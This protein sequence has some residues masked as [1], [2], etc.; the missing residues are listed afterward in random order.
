MIKSLTGIIGLFCLS[1]LVFLICAHSNQTPSGNIGVVV[2]NPYIFGHGGVREKYQEPGLSWY[3]STTAV[4][5]TSISPFRMDERIDHLSTA[6]NNFINYNSYLEMEYT[7]EMIIKNVKKFG[8][9]KELWYQN[10]VQQHYR[11][12]VR[13]VSMKYS[14]TDIMTNGET[15][16]KIQD[17]VKDKITKY[18]ATTDLKVLIKNVSMGKPMPNQS[19]IDEMDRTAV[20]QQ[21]IQTEK[22]KDSAEIARKKSET[23]RALA[24]NAYREQLNMTTNQFVEIEK[25]RILADA[26]IK[27]KNCVIVPS[28]S[29]GLM[30]NAN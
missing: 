27:S 2:D 19:V 28:G 17:E 16:S 5:N 8:M 12:I 7:P 6:D 15:L 24:D 23:S 25:A 9:N 18:V 22:N 13:E 26:C 14:M 11:T 20:Q 3:W 4:Y 30:V 21:R 1:G 29:S 10:M